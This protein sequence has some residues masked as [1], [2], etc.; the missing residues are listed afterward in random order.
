MALHCTV[1][2]DD[3]FHYC[4]YSYDYNTTIAKQI[5]FIRLLFGAINGNQKCSTLSVI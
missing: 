3:Y 2:K 1:S 5:L 4:M